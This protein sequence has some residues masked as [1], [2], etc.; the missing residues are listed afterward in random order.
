MNKLLSIIAGILAICGYAKAGQMSVNSMSGEDT[1]KIAES[2]ETLKDTGVLTK[3]Q[4]G[5]FDIDPE[6][7]QKLKMEGLINK[8]KSQIQTICNGNSL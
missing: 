8:K 7:I 5:C 4:D 6:V 3:H 2:L 1:K